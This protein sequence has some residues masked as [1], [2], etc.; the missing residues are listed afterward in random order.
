MQPF[1]QNIN[2]ESVEHKEIQYLASVLIILCLIKLFLCNGGACYVFN[3]QML[4]PQRKYFSSLH[5]RL[6]EPERSG[7]L[8][9]EF[10]S[11]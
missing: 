8:Y 2:T 6:G 3:T 7:D 1:K 5:G 11:A 4:F 10:N 9:Q